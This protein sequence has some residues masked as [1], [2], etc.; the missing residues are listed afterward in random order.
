MF[1]SRFNHRY[2]EHFASVLACP[3]KTIEE[4]KVAYTSQLEF[5]RSSS[6]F[7][8]GLFAGRPCGHDPGELHLYLQV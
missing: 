5:E 1:V 7:D 8:L 6:V 4:L 2:R 3:Y